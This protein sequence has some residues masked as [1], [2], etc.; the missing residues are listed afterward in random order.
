MNEDAVQC[1]TKILVINGG[2]ESEKFVKNLSNSEDIEEYK[3][4]KAAIL[5]SKI[6]V[7]YKLWASGETFPDI[8]HKVNALQS[9]VDALQS[10]VDIL[11]EKLDALINKPKP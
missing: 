2:K 6:N 9:E 7:F 10:E 3:D 8:F 5:K 1:Y 4:V 11:K